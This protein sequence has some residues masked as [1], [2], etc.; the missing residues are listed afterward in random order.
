MEW[1]T[2]SMQFKLHVNGIV[3]ITPP[4]DFAGPETLEHAIENIESRNEYAEGKLKAVLAHLPNHY[5]NTAATK[6]YK[7]ETPDVPIAL[8]GDSAFK[9]MI[10]NFMLKLVRPG[11]PIK[12][13][14]EEADAMTW[15]EQELGIT[16][17]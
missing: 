13:F 1:R 6:Y 9:T 11:R 17:P 16:N 3:V 5:V 4:E 14:T 2:T 7:Q 10:G 8:V 15:L 12:L